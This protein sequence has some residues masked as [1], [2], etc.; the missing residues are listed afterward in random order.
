MC[1]CG[2]PASLHYRGECT[3]IVRLPDGPYF[4]ECVQLKIHAP[5]TVPHP[6]APGADGGGQER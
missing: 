6:A 1:E 4:C 5:D 3:E 2:H